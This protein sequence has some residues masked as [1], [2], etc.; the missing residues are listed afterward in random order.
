MDKLYFAK[1]EEWFLTDGKKGKVGLTDFAQ[2]ELGDLVF[3]EMPAV[4]TKVT[5]GKP[6]CNV[7]SVKAVSEVYSPCCGTIV[8][9]NEDVEASPGK[10]NESPM[11]AWIVE[12]EV[13]KLSEGLM[14]QQAYDAAPRKQ[15]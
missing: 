2:N 9:I 3:V 13:E 8:A 7:E 15:R 1:T 11:E 6:L 4:G 12:I 14:D 5:G 10:I